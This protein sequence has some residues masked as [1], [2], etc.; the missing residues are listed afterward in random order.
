M[1]QCDGCKQGLVLIDGIHYKQNN[2]WIGCTANLYNKGEKQIKK[3]F[4]QQ[5]RDDMEF[6]KTLASTKM[7]EEDR[8]R[9][10][11]AFRSA[12]EFLNS[13]CRCEYSNHD[14]DV[15]S[16]LSSAVFSFKKENNNGSV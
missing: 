14:F 16:R 10:Y 1:T 12:E 4:A 11:G 5:M 9:I 7:S 15:A 8:N 3:S 6:V 13:G 2:P